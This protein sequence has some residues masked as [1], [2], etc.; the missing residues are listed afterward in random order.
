[1]EDE[2][3]ARERKELNYNNQHFYARV[4]LYKSLKWLG[5]DYPATLTGAWEE[6][7]HHIGNDRFELKLML[8]ALVMKRFRCML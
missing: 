7:L 8:H 1:M 6:V 3:R 2:A 5:N 4:I